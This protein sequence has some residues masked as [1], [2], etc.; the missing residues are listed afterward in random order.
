MSKEL[1]STRSPVTLPAV[2]ADAGDQASKK[3]IEFFAA[4]IRNK[5]PRTA[6]AQ[7]I[8]LFLRWCDERYFSLLALEPTIIG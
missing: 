3:F 2:I 7:A 5:N 6:Y 1:T 4:T 8:A